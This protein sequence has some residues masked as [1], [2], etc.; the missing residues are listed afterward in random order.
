VGISKEFSFGGIELRLSNYKYNQF[1]ADSKLTPEISLFTSF[2]SSTRS[3]LDLMDKKYQAKN[4]LDKSTSNRYKNTIPMIYKVT[5]KGYSIMEY[6]NYQADTWSLNKS[7]IKAFRKP[8]IMFSLT[9]Y[10]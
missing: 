9:K 8:E 4:H 10:F 7:D 5:L 6:S 2:E 1:H 3:P